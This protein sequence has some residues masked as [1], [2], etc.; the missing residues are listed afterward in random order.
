VVRLTSATSADSAS[1][2]IAPGGAAYWVASNL[3]TLAPDRTYQVWAISGG[4][5]VS[6]GVMGANPHSY[7]AL[8]LSSNMTRL[9]VT[10]EPE[11]GT[12]TPTT[13]VLVQA[14]LPRLV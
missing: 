14:V 7:A 6:I 2:V 1:I 9:M 3:A 11:G 12:T 10:A 13:P 8:R 4:R 5:V